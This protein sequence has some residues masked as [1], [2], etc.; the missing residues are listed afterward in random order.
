MFWESQRCD[1]V[2]EVV[3]YIHSSIYRIRNIG[4]STRR[5]C[6]SVEFWWKQIH[7]LQLQR[8][9]LI[10]Y[11]CYSNTATLNSQ[12]W[13][14]SFNFSRYGEKQ[15]FHNFHRSSSGIV[16]FYCAVHLLLHSRNVALSA[17]SS[18]LSRA[19]VCI[20]TRKPT[21]S[22][23]VWWLGCYNHSELRSIISEIYTRVII[24]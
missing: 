16:V 10:R 13:S 2:A 4:V 22:L 18:H 1:Y 9:F 17:Y 12:K 15:T 14:C 24:L 8:S 11:H 23:T 20:S 6:G 5:R 7:F 19:V 21:T 3:V